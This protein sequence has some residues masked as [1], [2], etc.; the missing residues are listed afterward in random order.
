MRDWDTDI[1]TEIRETEKERE[2]IRDFSRTYVPLTLH[3]TLSHHSQKIK[4]P[5]IAYFTAL[6]SLVA[7]QWQFIASFITKAILFSSL[8]SIVNHYLRIIILV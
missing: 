5:K 1:D 8:L 4:N 6:T 7:Q 2:R 3:D